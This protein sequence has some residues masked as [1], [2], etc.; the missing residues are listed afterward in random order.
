VC[1]SPVTNGRADVVML[2]ADTMDFSKLTLHQ[3]KRYEMESQVRVLEL[4]SQLENER[5]SLGELRKTHYRLAAESEG[6][7]QDVCSVS[8]VYSL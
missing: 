2:R 8:S 7:D 5:R 3:A 4:E 6:W 1:D